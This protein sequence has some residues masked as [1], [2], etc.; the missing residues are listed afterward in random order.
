MSETPKV[1]GLD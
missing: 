1:G